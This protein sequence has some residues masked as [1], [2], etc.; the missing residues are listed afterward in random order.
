MKAD[1]QEVAALVVVAVAAVA[2][3]WRLIRI[4]R[5]PGCGSGCACPSEKLRR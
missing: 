3:V 2:L 4:R 5:K 1:T